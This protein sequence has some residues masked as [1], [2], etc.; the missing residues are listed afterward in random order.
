MNT[1]ERVID[2]IELL[3]S[4]AGP[5][6]VSEISRQLGI[7]KN[8]TFRILSALEERGWIQQDVE[9]KKYSLTGTLA[10]IA[11]KALS[12]LDIQ[13]VSLPYLHELEAITGETSA[14]CI[15]VNQE[16]MFVNSVPSHHEV[17]R[18]VPLGIRHNLWY[19]SAGKVMLAFMPEAEVDTVM[20]TYKDTND[21]VTPASQ[22]AIEALRKELIE[23]RKQGFAIGAEERSASVC[24][25]AAPI[26]NHEQNVVGS[27]GVSGPMPRFNVDLALQYGPIV[28][29]KAKKVSTLLGATL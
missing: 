23:I 17:C 7:G 16:R 5:C 18:I 28:K 1:S 9:T 19:G 22:T 4:A 27:L 24:G 10:G 14:L 8:S 26:F 3:A 29:D 12:L 11:Y 2:I 21:P 25:V 15:R 20:Q 13:R 6:G